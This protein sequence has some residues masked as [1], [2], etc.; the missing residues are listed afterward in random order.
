M[1]MR[2]T[3]GSLAAAA[4]IFA[5][6]GGDDDAPIEPIGTT[7]TSGETDSAA[8]SKGDYLA[9]AD[10]S[11]AEANAAVANLATTTGD[12]LELASTQEQQ[13]TEGLLQSLQALEQPSDPDGSLE[14]Y[15]DAL[16]DQVSILEQRQTAAADGDTETYETLGGELAQAQADARLAAEEFGFEECGQ[17]GTATTPAT[18]TETPA[19]TEAPATGG[20]PVPVEPAPAPPAP[21]PAPEPVAPPPTSGGTGTGGGTDTGGGDTGGGDTGGTGGVSPG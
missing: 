15:L 5:G 16:S 12:N 18:T 1:L 14:R 7:T 20:T 4:V 2:L 8:V 11:C 6:C 10:P 19:G 17:E 21:A 3:L 13:I 9:E